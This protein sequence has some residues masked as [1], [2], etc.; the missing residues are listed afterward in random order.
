MVLDSNVDPRRVWYQA[1]LDQDIAFDR[2]INIWFGWLAKYDSVYHL[3]TTEKAVHDAVVR[4]QAQLAKHPA[5]G[6]IGPDEWTDAFLYAGYYQSTWVDLGNAFA[7]W[8]H[9]QRPERRCSTAYVNATGRGDDNGF[10]V[11]D[12]V[13][14]TDVQWPTAVEPVADDN[15]AI[16]AQ[17]PFE[18][19]GNAWYNA[20]CLY[21]PAKPGNAGD[22]H[23]SK[24]GER[25]ADRRD[26][27]RGHAVRGQPRGPQAVPALGPARGARAAPP[28]PTRC[29]AT[30]AWTTRS[31]AYLATGTLP[32]GGRAATGRRA[33]A[34]RCRSRCRRVAPPSRRPRCRRWR[35]P[36]GRPQ[37]LLTRP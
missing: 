1:N 4:D 17:A 21:W 3:G 26:A 6:M 36:P 37:L 15:W 19:W 32:T 20:P 25:A 34:R 8:I 31:R 16:Y 18:T 11:Y 22:D 29:S 10:A 14:C 9:K 2:N 13:Q 30:P 35:E 28:T 27:R 12:A 23:G 33:P 24:V 5:G 7:G